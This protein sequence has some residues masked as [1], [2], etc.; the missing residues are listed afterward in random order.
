M[1]PREPCFTGRPRSSL[2]DRRTDVFEEVRETD[3]ET[4]SDPGN[5]AQGR[6]PETRLD[7][8]DVGPVDARTLGE[9]FLRPALRFPQM[10]NAPAEGLEQRIHPTFAHGP[11]M[12]GPSH[13]VER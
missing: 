5:H 3:A 2:A 4:T 1:T 10:A 9:R 13:I 12:I 7:A 6:I 8:S 11:T